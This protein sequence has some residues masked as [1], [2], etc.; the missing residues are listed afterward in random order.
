MILEALKSWIRDVIIMVFSLAMLEALLPRGEIKKAAR[1][2]V[3]LAIIAVILAPLTRIRD[4]GWGASAPLQLREEWLNGDAG[5][6]SPG[7]GMDTGSGPGR[8]VDPAMAMSQEYIARG[9]AM[10]AAGE[11]RLTEEARRRMERQVE[12]L[13]GLGMSPG[14]GGARGG[15]RG[16]SDGGEASQGNMPADIS[17]RV[18]I[19]P[20]SGGLAAIEVSIK[21]DRAGYAGGIAGGRDIDT[22]RL[23]SLVAD[24]YGLDRE[25]VAVTIE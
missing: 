2:A 23:R 21:C 24:F 18:E 17:A 19:A 13:V 5:R 15:A 20:S 8:D 7:M 11:R 25:R 10:R 14:A 12:A 22:E 3:G 9:E 1:I 16:R 4:A 6:L